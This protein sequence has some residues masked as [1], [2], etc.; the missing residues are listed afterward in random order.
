[1]LVLLQGCNTLY[2]S[3]TINIEVLIPGTA[4]INPE[5]RKVA[6]KY[7]N[8]NIAWNPAFAKHFEDTTTVIDRSNSDS[9]ASKIY[10]DVFTRYLNEI[11]YFD[12]VTV[13]PE[14]DFSNVAISDSLVTELFETPNAVL[15][16]SRN[17]Q[18][19]VKLARLKR[20]FQES[21]TGKNIVLLIDPDF[22]LYTK[23]R[24]ETIARQTGADMFV[25]LD[26]FAA[27]DGIYSRSM[28]RYM[29]D[30]LQTDLSYLA[31][32][33]EAKEI[34]MILA[35]WSFYDLKKLEFSNHFQKIDT[36]KWVEPSYSLREAKRM[37]PP[38][39]DALYN[40]ADLAATEL[41]DFLVPHW[42]NVDRMYYKSG[43]TE[44]KKT[45]YLIQQNRWLEAAEIWK[46]NINNKNKMIAA[47]SMFNLGLACEMNG[48][49]NAAIDWI[50]KSFLF[51]G[52]QN[53]IH[54]FNCNN[55]IKVLAQRKLDIKK[56]EKNTGS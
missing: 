49:I 51:I 37:L 34:V 3:K 41:I 22:G 55:Y 19:V 4:K 48:D 40:A 54:A 28:Y 21:G 26:F 44:L 30:S 1:M 24:I 45:N 12:T 6:V 14:T 13:L 53:E 20:N 33:N 2:N 52:N 36:I 50:T 11:Q 18:E 38:R 27:L 17:Q 43:H 42:I 29:S 46:K 8:T 10:F 7:N 39:K 47:K 16:I 23:K 5:Y 15:N 25:S 32:F 31:Q 56:I 35:S 9:V